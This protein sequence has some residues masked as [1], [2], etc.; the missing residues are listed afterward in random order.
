VV[1]AAEDVVIARR[2]VVVGDGRPVDAHSA[3]RD[4]NAAT[5]AL[6]VGA[7]GAAGAAVAADATPLRATVPQPGT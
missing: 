4:M 6:A 3:A 2:G 5:D 7:A 1:E